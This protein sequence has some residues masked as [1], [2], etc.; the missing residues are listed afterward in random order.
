MA[1]IDCSLH[2]QTKFRFQ[3]FHPPYSAPRWMDGWQET[4]T[5]LFQCSASHPMFPCCCPRSS[6]EHPIK[7]GG[8]FLALRPKKSARVTTPTCVIFWRTNVSFFDCLRQQPAGT[9]LLAFETGL[10]S[11]YQRSCHSGRSSIMRHNVMRE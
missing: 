1:R 6:S 4:E 10:L 3:T 11:L 7:R 9:H 2:P 5:C 8:L